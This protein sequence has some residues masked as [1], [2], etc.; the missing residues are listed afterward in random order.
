MLKL[1]LPLPSFS[2]G[3]R[4]Y[5]LYLKKAGNIPVEQK[6]LSYQ[7]SNVLIRF[8]LFSQC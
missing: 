6:M 8:F 7:T 2:N 1:P 5:Y 3:V 4:Q